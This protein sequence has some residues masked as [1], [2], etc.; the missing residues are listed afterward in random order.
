MTPLIESPEGFYQVQEKF[1]VPLLILVF[2]VKRK[3]M[4]PSGSIPLFHQV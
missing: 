3:G 4:P 2:C 1:A